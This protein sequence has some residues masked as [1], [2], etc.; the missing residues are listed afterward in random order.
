VICE[1]YY[2]RV[3]LSAAL[4]ITITKSPSSLP[5]LLFESDNATQVHNNWKQQQS[6][7]IGQRRTAV[8][9]VGPVLLFGRRSD[10]TNQPDRWFARG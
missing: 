1:H 6:Y 5:P 3:A 7:D 9:A 10:R 4:S 2:C 8:D